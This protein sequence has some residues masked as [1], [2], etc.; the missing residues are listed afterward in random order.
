MII[1]AAH[2]Q[3][4][5]VGMCGEMASSI[6]YAKV[7]IGLGLDEFSMSSSKILKLKKE[8]REISFENSKKLADSLLKCSVTKEVYDTIEKFND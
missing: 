4:K 1:D 8:I 7:L 6:E 5:G 2:K 3:G